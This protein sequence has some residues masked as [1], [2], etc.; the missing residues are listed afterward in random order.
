[1]KHIE[2]Q[3]VEKTPRSKRKKIKKPEI[4]RVVSLATGIPVTNL[5]KTE[6]KKLMNLE[7]V[8]QNHVIGQDEAVTAVSKAI[9]RSRSGFADE[10]RP[11][12][13][14]IF[15]GPTGVGKTELVK[16]LA[17]QVYDD[18]DAMIKF[19]MSEFME[20]HNTSRLVGATAGYVGYEEGGQLTEAVRRKPYSVVLFDEIEK[21]H[22][23]VFNLLLQILEDGYLTDGRGRKVNFRNTIIVMTSNIGADKL[24]EKA[25]PIGFDLNDSELERAKK[26]FEGQKA[27]ILEDLKKFF[28]PEFLN[29]VDK[30]V[31]FQ[32]LKHDDV[33]EIVK[34]LIDKLQVRLDQKKIKISLTSKALDKL[35]ELSFDPKFGARPARRVIQDRI[36]DPLTSKYLEGEF[37]AGDSITISIKSDELDLQKK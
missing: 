27:L 5:V 30:T 14:F 15:M 3:K 22:K 9:R 4:A 35:A 26:D 6:M 1:M 2:D 20:R 34:L 37:K 19:D 16:Q 21:A 18:K 33:K 11:I 29:R 24:T 12:G 8:L 7:D 23:D 32:P 25:A 17:Q 13:S 10:N 31:I 28:R 36:E